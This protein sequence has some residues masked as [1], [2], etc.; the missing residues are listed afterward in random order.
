MS[1]PISPDH[2]LSRNLNDCFL[3]CNLLCQECVLFE[4]RKDYKRA[5]KK[6]MNIHTFVTNSVGSFK[7]TYPELHNHTTLQSDELSLFQSLMD[8]DKH[9]TNRAHMCFENILKIGRAKT[10]DTSTGPDKPLPKL[11]ES[12]GLLPAQKNYMGVSHVPLVASNGSHRA[13]FLQKQQT[14]S[15]TRQVIPAYQVP[16]PSFCAAQRITKSNQVVNK[17]VLSP[18]LQLPIAS[19]YHGNFFIETQKDQTRLS[20]T[21]LRLLD[22]DRTIPMIHE[23]S[24]LR[25]SLSDTN[26]FRDSIFSKEQVSSVAEEVSL[27]DSLSSKLTADELSDGILEADLSSSTEKPGKA[28]TE[29]ENMFFPPLSTSQVVDEKQTSD[30]LRQLM[31]DLSFAKGMKDTDDAATVITELKGLCESEDGSK[32]HLLDF[33]SLGNPSQVLLPKDKKP[34][35]PSV[36]SLYTCLSNGNNDSHGSVTRFSQISFSEIPRLEPSLEDVMSIGSASVY[37]KV[38]SAEEEL[39]KPKSS[40]LNDESWS[41]YADSEL[42]TNGSPASIDIRKHPQ[43]HEASFS[44]TKKLIKDL[45]RYKNQPKLKNNTLEVG[46]LQD[47]KNLTPEAL[48]PRKFSLRAKNYKISPQIQQSSLTISK[49]NSQVIQPE[50]QAREKKSPV[51]HPEPQFREKKSPPLP[52]KDRFQAARKQQ[53][54]ERMKLGLD[55]TSAGR[56]DRSFLLSGPSPTFSSISPISA[57]GPKPYRPRRKGYTSTIATTST[58]H[59]TKKRLKEKVERVLQETNKQHDPDI[60]ERSCRAMLKIALHGDAKTTL[61]DLGNTIHRDVKRKIKEDVLLPFVRPDLFDSSADEPVKSVLLAGP[62]GNRLNAIA[63][64]T[65]KD[66]KCLP[67]CVDAS[68]LLQLD[69]MIKSLFYVAKKMSPVTLIVENIDVLLG[70]DSKARKVFLREWRSLMRSSNPT[71]LILVPSTVNFSLADM[72]MSTD[73]V[74]VLLVATATQPW[75]IGDVTHDL[76]NTKIYVNLPDFELRKGYIRELI[77]KTPKSNGSDITDSDYT[78]LARKTETFSLDDLSGLVKEASMIPLR[79]LGDDVMKVARDSIRLVQKSDLMRAFLNAKATVQTDEVRRFEAWKA[80]Y[81]FS[82]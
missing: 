31:I 65:G 24:S 20:R 58:S 2:S 38:L 76:F 52:P 34:P 17:P 49:F 44:L 62:S 77:Q 1:F 70:E 61:N 68:R 7:R 9:A 57:V 25:R 42:I 11:P 13:L 30:S 22:F 72:D 18:P 41:A 32:L 78:E 47:L 4:I 64:A 5:Y 53:T 8:L 82:L 81:I 59:A 40:D 37:E 3:L 67:L 69:K 54:I 75:K 16:T 36:K 66:S 12:L 71:D 79:E 35:P 46:S 74:R 28:P 60:D 73:S 50:L 55:V 45:N 14:S 23:N 6:W 27:H 39:M 19:E 10:T 33:L 63:R 29:L 48:V 56:D 21:E 51:I 15:R 26:L 43:S 80:E